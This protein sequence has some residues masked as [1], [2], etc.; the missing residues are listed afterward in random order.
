MEIE[1]YRAK[2]LEE[3]DKHRF[4][5]VGDISFLKVKELLSQTIDELWAIPFEKHYDD[6]DEEGEYEMGWN[7]CIAEAERKRDLIIKIKE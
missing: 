2:K 7:A 5:F 1:K 4:D 3:F 6:E